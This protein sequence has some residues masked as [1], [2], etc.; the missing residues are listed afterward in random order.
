MA[1]VVAT[2]SFK[3]WLK[4]DELGPAPKNVKGQKI[5][6]EAFGVAPGL[7]AKNQ[8]GDI[9]QDVKLGETFQAQ[10][11]QLFEDSHPAV[12]KWPEKFGSAFYPHEP[13]IERATAA[14]GETR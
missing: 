5:E 6:G 11:G 7:P 14:P 8:Y 10:Q 9:I 2:S 4:R 12:K 3:G 1:T 13:R